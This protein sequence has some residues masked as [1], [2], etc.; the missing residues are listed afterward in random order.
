MKLRFTNDWKTYYPCHCKH[1]LWTGSSQDVVPQESY[2]YDGP[3]YCPFCL[4]QDPTEFETSLYTFS[5][6][7]TVK[8]YTLR[9]FSLITM[10]YRLIVKAIERYKLDKW[11]ERSEKQM[12]EYELEN[13]QP[14]S[15][16]KD[17]R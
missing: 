8:Y 4:K 9:A 15:R 12:M 6:K 7:D 3:F 17:K 14:P 2:E 11:I 13:Q 1:C 10:P 16:A 5:I